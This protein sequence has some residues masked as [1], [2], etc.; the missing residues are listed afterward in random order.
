MILSGAVSVRER[1]VSKK[2]GAMKNAGV[3]ICLLGSF[4]AIM[5]V[6]CQILGTDVGWYYVFGGLDSGMPSYRSINT[7]TLFLELI[8]ING[9]GRAL[10][11]LGKQQELHSPTTTNREEDLT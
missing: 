1:L 2:G 6:P 3:T 11:F 4:F 10:I 7:T 5:F 8:L 9:V